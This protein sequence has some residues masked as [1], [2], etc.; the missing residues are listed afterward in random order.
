MNETRLGSD[1]NLCIP[2]SCGVISKMKATLQRGIGV[3]IEPLFQ[4]LL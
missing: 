1:P 2:P 3:I 4:A